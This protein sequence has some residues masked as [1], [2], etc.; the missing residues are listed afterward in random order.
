M[1]SDQFTVE[2]PLAANALQAATISTVAQEPW[3]DGAALVFSTTDG[4]L[5]PVVVEPAAGAIVSV[6]GVSPIGVSPG[7]APVVSLSGVVDVAHGGTANSTGDASLLTNIPA[8]QLAGDVPLANVAAALAAGG[9]PVKGT[10]LTATTRLDAP[11]VGSSS[12]TQ[13]ALPSGTADLLS[14]DSSVVVTNKTISGSSNTLSNIGNSSLTNSSVTVS[15]GTGLAGG[16]SVSLGGSTSLTVSYGTTSTTATVGNDARLNPAP[17]TAGKIPYDTG[18]GYSETATGGSTTTVLHGGTTPAYAAV[19]LTADVTGTLP[20]SSGGTGQTS[21]SA[22]C[23]LIG[24]GTSGISVAAQGTAGQILTSQGA[25]ADPAMLDPITGTTGTATLA[26]TYTIS[27]INGA[28]EDTGLF[29]TLPSAGTY[30]VWYQARSNI[31]ATTTAGAYILTEMYNAT[32]ATD[33]ANSEQIGAY[34]TTVSAAY[35]MTSFVAMVL[36]VNASK[37][38]RMYAKC[39]VPSNVSVKTINSDANGRS[40]MG[41]VKINYV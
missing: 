9:G 14:A 17:S 29:V 34:G 37:V 30:Y 13:H 5:H 21:L 25:S 22:H 4:L 38:I 28:Y 20:V 7:V 40:R 10:V 8:A 16:G 11:S 39:V 41:Y 26:S 32:D 1:G 2:G 33:V 12:A 36:T 24:E 18:S 31:N 19:S 6:T 15:A 23:V 3:V 27:T 35:Y